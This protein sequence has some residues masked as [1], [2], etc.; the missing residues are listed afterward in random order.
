[1]AI[2]DYKRVMLLA[3]VGGIDVDDDTFKDIWRMNE[4][5]DPHFAVDVFTSYVKL[6]D[7]YMRMLRLHVY[8]ESCAHVVYKL[9]DKIR[10]SS[11][12]VGGRGVVHAAD[13]LKSA[14][15]G[16]EWERIRT[17]MDTMELTYS[18]FT[19]LLRRMSRYIGVESTRA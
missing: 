6:V 19:S 17:A 8:E 9:L 12:S 2:V 10:A 3:R 16:R 4:P 5:D 18:V 1:M 13:A 14:V 7:V 11:T 15:A